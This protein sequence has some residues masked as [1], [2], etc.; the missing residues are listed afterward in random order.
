ME[1]WRFYL[2]DL[3]QFSEIEAENNVRWVEAFRY[4]NWLDSTGENNVID[5]KFAEQVKEN[6]EKDV[7]GIELAIDYEHGTDPARG[8]EASG[9]VKDMVV[10]DDKM[11]WAIE[12]TEE[13]VDA[14]K[15]N[16]FRY[17]SP[18]WMPEWVHNGT[19]MKHENV[20]IGGALTNR[21]IQ[22]GIAAVNFA[23]ILT[24]DTTLEVADWEHH[25]PGTE[26]PVPN[27][28]GAE[29]QAPPP[30]SLPDE[31]RPLTTPRE[32]STVDEAELRAHLEIGEDVDINEHL[33]S[34]M[35]DAK[36]F[37][38]ADEA[39]SHAR[40]FAEEFPEEYKTQQELLARG[41][42]SDAKEFSET[43]ERVKIEGKKDEVGLSPVAIEAV[44]EFH[45][46]LDTGDAGSDDLKAVL[47]KVV[48]NGIVRFGEDGSSAEP[49]DEPDDKVK[50]FAEKMAENQR[51]GDEG[52]AMTPGDALAKTATDHPELYQAY[53]DRSM[54]GGVR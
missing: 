44:R 22:K 31:P 14:I 13:A 10:L 7:R 25:E 9:W 34:L 20:P 16:K 24:P 43:Y 50:A 5:E 4:G 53:R 17:F 1:A 2:T 49:E 47:D 3:S 41:R 29:P 12:F 40:K 46:K 51:T 6:F 54:G 19:H 11:M 18:T 28:P 48:E 36:A 35:A 33:T 21:P 30:P 8:K 45:E 38:E 15:S 23:E 52:K 37:A 26:G 42:R 39:A 27:E 32:G